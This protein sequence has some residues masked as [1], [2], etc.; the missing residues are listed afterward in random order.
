MPQMYELS[1]EYLSSLLNDERFKNYENTIKNIIKL[2]PHRLDEKT[3]TL[4]AD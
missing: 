4:L 1:D 3:S 2:K